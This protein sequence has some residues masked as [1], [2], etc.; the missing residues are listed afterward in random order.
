MTD[1]DGG[2]QTVD[3]SFLIE[4]DTTLSSTGL[5]L[6][7][8]GESGVNTIDLEAEIVTQ[9]NDGS[10]TIG[11][12]VVNVTNNEILSQINDANSTINDAL[13]ALV[14]GSETNTTLSNTGLELTYTGESGINTIDLESEILTQINDG[15]SNINDALEA[16]VSTAIPAD[17]G[18]L[19]LVDNDLTHTKSDGTVG[20]AI[21]LSTLC[22]GQVKT[23]SV[24]F[25]VTGNSSIVT[26]TFDTSVNQILNVYIDGSVVP[27]TDGIAYAG[28]YVDNAGSIDFILIG[29][30]DANYTGGLV[31]EY[32]TK[33]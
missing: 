20:T 23:Q 6:T 28:R 29:N 26:A 8:T 16:L 21:D 1:S 31:V 10:S 13:E 3:L 9:I 11:G 30:P 5:E 14:S 7:Y 15:T 22:L 2:S 32:I 19:T 18:D 12:A 25:D 27:I 4:T 33:C 24:A 17:Q